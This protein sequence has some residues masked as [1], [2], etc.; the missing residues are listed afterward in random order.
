LIAGVVGSW[1]VF[2]SNATA[3]KLY[4]WTW[5]TR[6]LLAVVNIISIVLGNGHFTHRVLFLLLGMVI[7]LITLYFFK[8][9]YFD[10]Y[11]VLLCMN[12]S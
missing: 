2:G 11:V 6:L 1:A 4:L 7:F 3:A 9:R 10:P 5:A 8:V 12:S